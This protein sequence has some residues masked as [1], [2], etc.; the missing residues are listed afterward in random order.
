MK[1]DLI[2]AV[3]PLPL[4]DLAD[5]RAG[6]TAEVACSF[7]GPP[8]DIA[9]KAAE[10][11]GRGVGYTPSFPPVADDDAEVDNAEGPLK[12]DRSG[13]GGASELPRVLP[14]SPRCCGR[15]ETPRR[16]KSGVVPVPE[17]VPIAAEV[18]PDL[19]ADRTDGP[20]AV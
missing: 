4:F 16:H 2:D 10:D 17:S 1:K 5:G 13:E 11:A 8:V 6:V 14:S 12:S 7:S 19:Q 18:G 9:L 15:L 3:R 20:P